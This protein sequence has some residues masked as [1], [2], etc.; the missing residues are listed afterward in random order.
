MMKTNKEWP[1]GINEIKSQLINKPL[2]K[3]SLYVHPY[4]SHALI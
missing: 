2:T 1:Q 3:Q 4:L